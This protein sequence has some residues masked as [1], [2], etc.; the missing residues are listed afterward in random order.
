MTKK[1][2]KKKLSKKLATTATMGTLLLADA[3]NVGMVTADMVTDTT[4]PSVPTLVEKELPVDEPVVEEVVE[5]KKEQEETGQN[6]EDEEES[7]TGGNTGTVVETTQEQEKVPRLFTDLFESPFM[8]E[9]VVPTLGPDDDQEWL[10]IARGFQAVQ[11]RPEAIWNP[12]G[13]PNGTL[14]VIINDFMGVPSGQINGFSGV[15]RVYV[16]GVLHEAQYRASQS[17]GSVTGTGN[18]IDIVGLEGVSGQAEIFFWNGNNPEHSFR[19]QAAGGETVTIPSVDDVRVVKAGRIEKIYD[20]NDFVH[21]NSINEPARVSFDYD[22]ETLEIDLAVPNA[23]LRFDSPNVGVNYGVIS[24]DPSDVIRTAIIAGLDEEGIVI[25]D[26]RI[27]DLVTELTR[28]YSA[29]ELFD[30][31]ITPFEINEVNLTLTQGRL[32]KSYDGNE[33]VRGVF[34]I[35]EI[36]EVSFADLPVPTTGEGEPPLLPS[37]FENGELDFTSFY[38]LLEFYTEN[39]HE[40]QDGKFSA[41]VLSIPELRELFGVGENTNFS[42]A[43]DLE[44]ESHDI[45]TDEVHHTEIIATGETYRLYATNPTEMIEGAS[46]Q[47][48]GIQTFAGAEP[49]QV[50]TTGVFTG[51][52]PNTTYYVVASSNTSRNFHIG[53]DTEIMPFTTGAENVEAPGTEN[54]SADTGTTETPGG[55]LPSTGDSA[56]L[57]AMAAGAGLLGV[58]GALKAYRKRKN[59]SD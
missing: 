37:G 35:A 8:P 26:T 57:G 40:N 43:M 1:R 3:A 47:L 7:Q 44:H 28:I 51:L 55:Q 5:E 41:G 11:V 10:D 27:S 39:I 21:D 9:I 12:P 58:L 32:K 48:R 42:A 14:R 16:D 36:P 38:D 19:L 23:N 30:A 6:T 33:L 34:D 53:P 49:L 59:S 45:H 31:T 17:Q 2:Q 46:V 20:G 18:W 13:T 15:V 56:S 24:G 52:N 50:N 29:R 22:G 54:G 4:T 25:H